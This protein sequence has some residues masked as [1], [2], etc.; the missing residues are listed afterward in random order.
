MNAVAYDKRDYATADSALS[1]GEITLAALES[2]DNQLNTARIDDITRTSLLAAAGMDND[3]KPIQTD[4]EVARNKLLQFA[5]KQLDPERVFQQLCAGVAIRR[6]NANDAFWL[7]Q[8]IVSSACALAVREAVRRRRED[9]VNAGFDISK[10]DQ[11]VWVGQEA[12]NMDVLARDNRSTPN[13]FSACDD[14]DTIEGTFKDWY[15]EIETPLSA[16]AGACMMREG[17]MQ[18]GEHSRWVESATGWEQVIESYEERFET[19]LQLANDRNVVQ[20]PTR[21]NAWANY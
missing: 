21:D 7:A 4:K 9:G 18:Y 5:T 16:L 15:K 12:T 8:R 10:D 11:D 17:F 13:I 6:V 1:H 20:L 14:A 19:A 2:I 3:E